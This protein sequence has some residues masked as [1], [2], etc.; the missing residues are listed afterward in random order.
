[1]RSS[2]ISGRT[3]CHFRNSTGTCY[4]VEREGYTHLHLG[5]VR[6]IR[7]LHGNKGLPVTAR[8][9]L[10]DTRL[11]DYQHAVIGTVLTTLHAGSVL[12]TFYPN[13]NLSLDDPNLPTT[14]KVQIQIQRAEQTVSSK[15]AT[16]HHQLVYRLQN[17]ALNLPTPQ[18][19]IDTIMILTDSSES[20][21]SIVQIPR[22]IQKQEL[23][24]LMPPEWLSN[25]E[26]F[27]QNS[28]PV[29]TTDAHL[30]KR[31]DGTVKL[32]FQ[33]P[34]TSHPPSEQSTPRNSFSYSFMI[35][36][37]F[38]AQEDLPIHEFASY[39]YPIYPDKI[40]GNFLWDVPGSHMCDPD[41]P[42]LEDEEED[43]DFNRRPKHRKK[44]NHKLDPCHKK[45]PLPPDDSDKENSSSQTEE[46]STDEESFTSDSEKEFVDVSKLFMAQ[47]ST[48]SNDPSSS[49]PPQTPI[50]EEADSDTNPQAPHQENSSAKPSNG[51]WFS[52]DDVPK[53]KDL[54]FHY[55][56]M[57]TMYY[58]LSGFNDP[59]LKHVFVAS[60]PKKIQ[61]ELQRKF[62]IHQLDI[63]N[64]S[65]RKIYQT[66][67]KDSTFLNKQDYVESRRNK[68]PPKMVDNPVVF[69]EL[70]DTMQKHNSSAL[71]TGK[72]G[73]GFKQ[74]FVEEFLDKMEIN[75][76]FVRVMFCLVNEFRSSK[77]VYRVFRAYQRSCTSHTTNKIE[78][79]VEYSYIPES[80]QISY[81]HLHLGGIRLILT[82]H[83]RK[84]LPV[85]ARLAMLD[86]RF[87]QYQDAVIGTVLTTLHAGSVLLTF[88]PNFNL[89]LQDPN[90]PTTLK[91]QV[92]IQ[93]PIQTSESM[94]ERRQDETVR[95]TFKPPP[96]D[97]QE[98][99]RLSFTYSSMITAV[100]TTQEDLPITGFNSAGYHVYPAKQNDHFL[101]DALGSGMCDPNCPCWDDWEEDDDYST[102]RKK[103]PKKKNSPASC[104]HYDPTPPQDPPP[105]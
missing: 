84:G 4:P 54:D 21:P 49:S 90:L 66:R 24:K 77:R 65:L 27:H 91:V 41:C 29:Q 52:F 36:A 97:P 86:T 32:T 87:K 81:T 17:H 31:A 1:M 79:L 76:L 92:Q 9:A 55:K 73:I 35:T 102:T 80:A 12:L 58:K 88:Y 2:G 71:A 7:T 101:W 104:H 44:K 22:Q 98:P 18:T 57:S 11:K 78:N 105:P 28:Q 23:L 51:L 85:I 60:L 19:T 40:N 42:Y 99:P 48:R 64:L 70:H 5:G 69:N 45:P 63:A 13:F 61:L 83:G 20:I 34:S 6:L 59:S 25:Y 93:A 89:S 82:L 16:L 47:P 8:L 67:S 46:I 50:V 72:D 75:P 37:V 53:I 96:S 100:Q 56:R 15:M 3:I 94:F 43:D 10:L 38:T 14:L 103:K 30:Q 62:T 74:D 68:T 39:G 33:S 95:M 26:K